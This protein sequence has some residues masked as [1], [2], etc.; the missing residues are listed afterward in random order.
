MADARVRE[1]LAVADDATERLL[2]ALRGVDDTWCRAPSGL[3]DWSRGHV[4]THLAR[5]ADGLRRLATSTAEGRSAGLY[6]PGNAREA[7]IEAGA[8]RAADELV[9]DV[10]TSAARLAETCGALPDHLWD[11]V[12]EWRAGRRQPLRDIP[13]ARVVEV[14]L[15]RVDLADGYTPA[16]WPDASS[17]LLL[18][19]AL[20]RAAG[21]PHPLRLRVHVDGQPEP[22][23]SD[24]PDATVS[25]P[26][27]LLVAWLTGRG[28]GSGL[29]SDDPLPDPPAAWS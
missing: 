18:A 6:G 20:A 8:D 22:R 29:R 7:D 4:L 24:D 11:V 17:D 15:H 27:H 23:G 16:D 21:A 1:R 9:D 10:R 14:E 3:P 28:D 12:T 13:L 26:A 25:G 19:A 5:N 2:E